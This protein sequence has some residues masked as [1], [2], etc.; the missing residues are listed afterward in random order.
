MNRDLNP[1]RRAYGAS[2]HVAIRC[3]NI[4][5]TAPSTRATAGRARGTKAER[6]LSAAARVLL[7]LSA[8]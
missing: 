1:T 2:K 8:V 5:D 3:V 4:L 6:R 7:Y